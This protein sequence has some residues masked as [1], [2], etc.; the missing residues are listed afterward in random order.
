[1]L[2]SSE[3]MFYVN[4]HVTSDYQNELETKW[5]EELKQAYPVKVNTKELKKIK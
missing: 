3:C 1:M 2:T 4:G 5:V